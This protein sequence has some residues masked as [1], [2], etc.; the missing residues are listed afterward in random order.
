M[1][2]DPRLNALHEDVRE[3]RSLVIGLGKETAANSVVLSKN[4]ADVAEHIRRTNVL[5]EQVQK[6]HWAIKWSLLVAGGFAAALTAFADAL[7]L[8]ALLRKLF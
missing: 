6:I 3:I 5:E 8:G 2:L 7:G 4:T 1:E